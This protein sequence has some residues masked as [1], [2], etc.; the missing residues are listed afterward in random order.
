M[1]KSSLAILLSKLAVFSKPKAELEQYPTD[2]ENASFVLWHAYMLHDIENKVIAD[3]GCGTGILG[4]GALLLGAKKCF[5]VDKSKEDIEKAKENLAMLEKETGMKLRKKA[6]FIA[7]E[8][9]TFKEKADTVIQ[10]PPF[11]NDRVFLEKALE[12]SQVSWSMHNISTLDFLKKFLEKRGKLTNIFKIQIELKKT[13]LWHTR[14]NRRIDVV[15][16]RV[17]TF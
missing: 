6:V 3:L 4:L 2:S 15:C 1:N 7:S 17:E 13:M 16:L 14:K 10:N 12:I 8:I 9:E 5:F 11:N